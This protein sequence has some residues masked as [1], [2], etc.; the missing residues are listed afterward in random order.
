[1]K[2][3]LLTATLLA[4]ALA[5]RA[6]EHHSIGDLTGDDSSSSVAVQPPV[7]VPASPPP[8]AS[9]PDDGDQIKASKRRDIQEQIDR[10]EDDI[11]TMRTEA[12]KTTRAGNH[13]IYQGR[14]YT[15]SHFD[16]KIA[17]DQRKIAE[18]KEELGKI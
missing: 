10:L 13:E 17:E 15:L 16:E 8:S 4:L 2:A 12:A 3:L 11:R 1:M 7:Q 9:A 5:A 14:E 6:Q 18:L